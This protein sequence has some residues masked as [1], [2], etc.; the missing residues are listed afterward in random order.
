ML[1]LNSKVFLWAILHFKETAPFK[2]EAKEKGCLFE[3][4]TIALHCNLGVVHDIVRTNS[5]KGSTKIPFA[6]ASIRFP[7]KSDFSRTPSSV[8]ALMVGTS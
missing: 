3:A 1:R 4:E 6:A 2:S 5:T 7:W 8:L